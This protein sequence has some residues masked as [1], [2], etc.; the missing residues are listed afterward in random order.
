MLF[1]NVVVPIWRTI[2]EDLFHTP[3]SWVVY[4]NETFPACC[5]QVFEGT[6]EQNY[7]QQV[8]F[9]SQW[10]N[11]QEGISVECQLSTRRQSELHSKQ[12]WTCLGGGWVG[13]T[14]RSKLMDFQVRVKDVMEM[15]TQW[16]WNKIFSGLLGL[17]STAGD[18]Y[19]NYAPEIRKT[20]PDIQ[21][22]HLLMHR[23]LAMGHSCLHC[24]KYKVCF[25]SLSTTGYF[26]AAIQLLQR[27]SGT[28]K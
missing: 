17:F 5:N 16:I 7:S 13:C 23:D 14:V 12:V 26:P 10:H 18:I 2:L 21:F 27:M 8:Y 20:T 19:L 1:H 4:G 11:K 24:L 3:F 6:A 25:G 9:L 15:D 28:M 22:L